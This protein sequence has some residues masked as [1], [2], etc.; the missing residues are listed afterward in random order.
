VYQFIHVKW[1]TP[2]IPSSS[3]LFHYYYLLA[4]DPWS[5]SQG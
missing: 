5:I 4:A 2:Y 1:H 3:Q